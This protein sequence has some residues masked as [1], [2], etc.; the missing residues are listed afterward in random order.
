[1]K[2][3][4]LLKCEDC[5]GHWHPTCLG[6]GKHAKPAGLFVCADCI[7]FAALI[8]DQATE[9]VKDASHFL[10]W[11]DAQRVRE[12]SQNTY[13][14]GLHRFVKWAT[15]KAKLPLDQVLPPGKK[16]AVAVDLIRLFMAWACHRYKVSTIESTLSAIKDWHKS[17]GADYSH[18][19]SDEIKNLLQ[20]IRIEQGTE[21]LPQGKVGMTKPMLRLLLKY[22]LILRKNADPGWAQLH[23]RDLVWILLGFYGMLRRSELIALRMEDIQM[24]EEGGQS[25]IELTIRKSKTDQRGQGAQVTI[26][27][28]TTDQLNIAGYLQQWIQYRKSVGAAPTDP[29]FTAWDLDTRQLSA[30]PITTGQALAERLKLHLGALLQQYP[31]LQINPKAYGMHSLRRGGV[32]AAWQA[33]VPVDKIKAHGRWKSDAVRAYM[34]TTR[35]MRLQVTQGM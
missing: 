17:K 7:R 29:L 16:G 14:S 2:H 20:S 13:A 25:Y 31:D 12:S 11:L 30:S 24:G 32:M 23:L 34:Q 22:L 15:E 33:G 1:M 5:G 28:V 19:R 21:G 10:V 9:D 35:S 26:S 27:G 3:G 18:L 6:L 4:R 8:P